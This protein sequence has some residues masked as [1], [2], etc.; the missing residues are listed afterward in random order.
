ME[1]DEEGEIYEA[2]EILDSRMDKRRNDPITE[3]KGCLMYKIKYTG[4]EDEIPR[5]QI[6]TDTAECPDLVADFHHRYPKKAGP[7][8]SFK[9]PENWVPLLAILTQL[10][11]Q[12]SWNRI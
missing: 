11:R 9:K 3:H 1:I 12:K 8:E 5:W 4:Y 6:F 10:W 7:H 2:E